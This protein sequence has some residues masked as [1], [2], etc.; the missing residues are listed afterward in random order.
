MY[1]ADS[2][3]PSPST[4]TSGGEYSQVPPR[5]KLWVEVTDIRRMGDL[6]CSKVPASGKI[7]ENEDHFEQMVV[8][9][10]FVQE[11][12]VQTVQETPQEFMTVFADLPCGKSHPSPYRVAVRTLIIEMWGISTYI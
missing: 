10:E 3:A 4:I 2:S 9:V 12:G 5:Q 7:S 6:R 11:I 8:Y 1:A